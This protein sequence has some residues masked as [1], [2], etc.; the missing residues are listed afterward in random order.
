LA[1]AHYHITHWTFN[2]GKIFAFLDRSAPP[3]RQW[4]L[5]APRSTIPVARVLISALG[6]QLGG[7]LAALA[8][9]VQ[10]AAPT[11]C[12]PITILV[13][14]SFAEDCSWRASVN[15]STGANGAIDLTLTLQQGGQICLPVAREITFR[16]PLGLLPAGD[17]FVSARWSDLPAAPVEHAA[18]AVLAGECPSFQRGDANADGTQNLS[19][20]VAILSYL[21]LGGSIACVDASDTD[22]SSRVELTDAVYLLN[23]LFLGG[24]SPGAPFPDCGKLPEDSTPLGCAE[25]RCGA[26]GEGRVWMQKADGCVQCE[27]C[28]APSIDEVVQGLELA[29]IE[30]FESG[31]G[32][33]AAC[34]ACHVCPSG[35]VYRVLVAENDVP[36][37]EQHDWSRAPGA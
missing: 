36:E 33:L 32:Q 13:S 24:P 9:E 10:P 16:I 17:Y 18:F 29:D 22:S 1:A 11:V 34:E 30:V 23:H 3:A 12:E 4:R 5:V 28:T 15:T 26:T 8:V 35:R 37:L 7:A 19:D 6:L 25:T 31:I 20:A 14:R 21:F 2:T 27:P